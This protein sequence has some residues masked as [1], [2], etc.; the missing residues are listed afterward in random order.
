MKS[1]KTW[2]DDANEST[3][4][5]VP[6]IER[7]TKKVLKGDSQGQR[8]GNDSLNHYRRCSD[9][10]C[11]P[12]FVL[13]VVFW[14]ASPIILACKG[15]S[16]DLDRLTHGINSAGEM[17]PDYLYYCPSTAIDANIIKK[18]AL[19]VVGAETTQAAI[20]S[21]ADKEVLAR[22]G[23]PWKLNKLHRVCVKTCPGPTDPN[24]C[25]A[26]NTSTSTS[27]SVAYATK[28]K[29][30]SDTCIP[31]MD[32]ISA[33]ALTFDQAVPDGLREDVFEATSGNFRLA[34][35]GKY[36]SLLLIV[37]PQFLRAVHGLYYNLWRFVLITAGIVGI[38]FVYFFFTYNLG[39]NKTVISALS[40][41]QLILFLLALFIF[42]GELLERP[43][44]ITKANRPALLPEQAAGLNS[45]ATQD[46][47]FN[48]ILTALQDRWKPFGVRK[49]YEDVNPFYNEFLTPGNARLGSWTCFSFFVVVLLLLMMLTCCC[50]KA[51]AVFLTKGS[52]MYKVAHMPVTQIPALWF[53]VPMISSIY[54]AIVVVLAAVGLTYAFAFG[55]TE[56]VTFEKNSI[57]GVGVATTQRSWDAQPFYKFLVGV[58]IFG[59][60]WILEFISGVSQFVVSYA[61][62]RWYYVP[63]SGGG[64]KK[65][66]RWGSCDVRSLPLCFCKDLAAC[67][68]TVCF[69]KEPAS[70]TEGVAVEWYFINRGYC[71]ALLYHA[72]TIA[73]GSFFIFI[74][75]VLRI[76][77]STMKAIAE[78]ME[79]AHL[80]TLASVCS[81]MCMCIDQFVEK[82]DCSA[83]MRVAIDF[84]PF[85]KSAEL[86]NDVF[87]AGE[88]RTNDYRGKCRLY[89]MIG[90]LVMSAI[91]FLLSYVVFFSL[92]VA[93]SPR[94]LASIQGILGGYIAYEFFAVHD[95]AADTVL[96]TYLWNKHWAH[97]TVQ[98]YA[99]K[100]LRTKLRY[101]PIGKETINKAKY[102]LEG[103]GGPAASKAWNSMV[104]GASSFFP[105]F[106]KSGKEKDY[107]EHF[108]SEMLLVEA[109]LVRREL[110]AYLQVENCTYDLFTNKGRQA[111]R[112]EF[113]VY[114]GW[115]LRKNAEHFTGK[116]TREY[117][118]KQMAG[119]NALPDKEKKRLKEFYSEIYP[120]AEE[121]EDEEDED[122][123]GLE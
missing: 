45:T 24:P 60:F 122:E 55:R 81:G 96:H 67:F 29:K 72:G 109:D 62:L 63:L 52:E 13:L 16:E 90:V 113:E 112:Q 121:E 114:M 33:I 2:Q 120:E 106:E 69:P 70:A 43:A 80:N 22:I 19:H 76:F 75:R 20:D 119:F 21:A 103:L 108:E 8:D 50:N 48:E 79:Q 44:D 18:G 84:Q 6:G 4:F 38:C 47:L 49:F 7:H 36:A 9:A 26:P 107:Q 53:V 83:Y 88:K 3:R 11:L 39:P 101:S 78:V 41:F 111:V 117:D 73:K 31:D 57:G 68:G 56:Y 61:T 54:K 34:M 15:A 93:S 105:G 1:V 10:C 97:G 102:D 40:L 115:L 118:W 85:F 82:C 35:F 100:M 51:F 91:S 77:I 42:I 99:P 94:I 87:A 5:L 92:D 116:D 23:I 17:C 66:I 65:K 59:A 37:P 58:Y 123:E 89:T 30:H 27:S 14:I 104:S 95:V 86:V 64:N 25:A 98:R 46:L 28:A 74:F 71:Y 12:P 32:M 110:P